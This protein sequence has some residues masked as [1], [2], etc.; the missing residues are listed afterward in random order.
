[1]IHTFVFVYVTD[2][3]DPEVG[4][5]FT[6]RSFDTVWWFYRFTL[7]WSLTGVT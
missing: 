2:V 3:S 7:R 4:E 5:S 1:M 6:D